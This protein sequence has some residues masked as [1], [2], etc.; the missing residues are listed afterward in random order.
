LLSLAEHGE[1][2]SED[3]NQHIQTCLD[4]RACETACPSGV[5][6]H[7]LLDSY[8]EQKSQESGP[9]LIAR[10][11]H[12]FAS[13]RTWLNIIFKLTWLGQKTHILSVLSGFI[14]TLRGL[15]QI[16]WKPFLS[17]VQTNLPAIGK[18]RGSVAFFVGCVMDNLYS[19]VHHAS[20]RILRWNGYDV[21][22][23][24]DQNCCGA[25][26]HHSGGYQW[27]ERLQKRNV[28]AFADYDVIIN[29]SAGCGAELKE[30]PDK[31]FSGKVMDISDFLTRI[32]LLPPAASNIQQSKS[33]IKDPGS[34]IIYDAPCH[35][36]HGQQISS[37]P[38]EL[39]RQFGYE[40]ARFPN[41]DSCCG[42]AGSYM[43]THP[44][45]SNEILK[46]KMDEINKIQDAN[47]I[48][49][50]NPGCQLQLS[51][52]CEL[53]APD[54]RVIHICEAIDRVYQN[55]PEY[56]AMR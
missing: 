38:E 12:A 23:P 48:I 21:H 22:I 18:R 50:A 17:S 32:D 33:N 39:L 1:I 28:D 31:D 15:P 52:G 41:R 10:T 19:D 40:I 54:K 2:I 3:T 55:N 26:H 45:Y 11:A 20:V 4:C 44:E 27:L 5:D 13:S 7:N 46:S 8:L 49:T 16:S 25:L 43:L 47:I 14:P 30:Y 37:Q 56:L 36:V 29:N 35:L 42:A 9:G 51:K 24:K 53:Y 6:F 34:R